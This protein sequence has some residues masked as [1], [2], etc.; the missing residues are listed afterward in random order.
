MFP[1]E[2]MKMLCGLT[3]ALVAGPPSGGFV[4]ELPVPAYL[5]MILVE[6]VIMRM[7]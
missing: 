1:V 3:E 4:P 6:I 5:V 2:S 7:T